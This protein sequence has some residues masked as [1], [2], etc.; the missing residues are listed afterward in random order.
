[1]MGT[2]LI[3][4]MSTTLLVQ[5]GK[6]QDILNAPP[7]HRLY[8]CWGWWWDEPPCQ[9]GVFSSQDT[10]YIRHGIGQADYE[11]D[12]EVFTPPYGVKVFIEF[13]PNSGDWDEVEIKLNRFSHND[14]TGEYDPYGEFYP[15]HWWF[16][17]HVFEPNFF[18]P[19]WHYMRSEFTWYNGYGWFSYDGI[20]PEFR[21]EINYIIDG[22]FL[23]V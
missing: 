2:L 14:K 19:G 10:L 8:P 21:Q 23:I 18:E 22:Y 5:S 20:T 9:L 1:M 12:A 13:T 17:Y 16:F 7:E 11:K 4:I 3:L 6:K 15:L